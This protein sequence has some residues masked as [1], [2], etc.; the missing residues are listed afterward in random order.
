VPLPLCWR[1][2]APITWST[3]AN[4]RLRR[5]ISGADEI[6]AASPFLHHYLDDNPG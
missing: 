1:V 5:I 6:A 3:I 2:A 4:P